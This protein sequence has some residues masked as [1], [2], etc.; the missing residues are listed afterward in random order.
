MIKIAKAK[1]TANEKPLLKIDSD[2]V[3]TLT[4]KKKAREF[5][6]TNVKIK[7]KLIN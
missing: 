7:K 5:H 1:K 2:N 4:N 6:K 3:I